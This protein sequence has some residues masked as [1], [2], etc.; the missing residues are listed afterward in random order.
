MSVPVLALDGT[1]LEALA[2]VE[3]GG[4]DRAVGRA[5]EVSRYQIMPR[6][7]R[8]A[9]QGKAARMA[10]D[11]ATARQVATT[12][13]E[14]RLARF[15]SA[16][17]REPTAREVYALW[18]APGLLEREGWRYERLPRVVRQRCDRFAQEIARRQAPRCAAGKAGD[19][20]ANGKPRRATR[21]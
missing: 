19:S 5:G 20:N 2:M 16:T 10:H 8:Q 12:I 1:V 4:N 7:W 9:V 6:L 21:P 13:L 15:K 17:T 11:A 14:G 18:N 3:S